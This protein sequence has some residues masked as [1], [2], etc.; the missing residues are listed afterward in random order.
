MTE[1]LGERQLP[2][3]LQGLRLDRGRLAEV[4]DFDPGVG[5]VQWETRFECREPLQH[6]FLVNG[7]ILLLD[8]LV[9]IHHA[10]DARPYVGLVLQQ[11]LHHLGRQFRL[12]D[13]FLVGL[14]VD[15]VDL[16]ALPRVVLADVCLE[17][18]LVLVF[19]LRLRVV[20]HK[21]RQH[22]S[23]PVAL[24]FPSDETQVH[25]FVHVFP[26]IRP[27]QFLQFLLLDTARQHSNQKEE[28][29][30]LLVLLLQDLDR[31]LQGQ[32]QRSHRRVL[33]A[34]HLQHLEHLLRVQQLVQLLQAHADQNRGGQYYRMR[35]TA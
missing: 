27:P 17:H 16:F 5:F 11:L 9:H 19:D 6:L 18:Q 35:V 2:S 13:L 25:K 10:V 28:L 21:R 23:L 24:L 22:H 4:I 12:P 33:D 1:V 20:A 30:T 31:C 26:V 8:R 7:Q 34:V 14:A 29:Q 32:S 15:P 3:Q